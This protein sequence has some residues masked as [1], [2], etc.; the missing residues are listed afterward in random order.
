MAI[1]VETR[2]P[3]LAAITGGLS[4]PAIHPIAL[5]LVHMVYRAVARDAGVPII[6]A[7]GVTHW[8]DAA[9][10]ILA[11]AS[12]VEMGSALFADPR[13]PLRVARGLEKCPV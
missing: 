9:E 11:G 2:R 3:R 10:F 13:S 12:A 8:D 6:G 4:G 1:D 7:G 5:R